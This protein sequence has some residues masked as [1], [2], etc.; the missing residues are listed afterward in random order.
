MFEN[1]LV[2][3]FER[4]SLQDFISKELAIDIWLLGKQVANIMSVIF[5]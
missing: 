4:R 1:I 2:G 5:S 3:M